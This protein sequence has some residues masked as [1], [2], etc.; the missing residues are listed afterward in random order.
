M[1]KISYRYLRRGITLM[2]VVLALLIALTVTTLAVFYY[3]SARQNL[4]ITDFTEEIRVIET[5]V[6]TLYGGSSY[7]LDRDLNMQDIIHSN[8]LPAKYVNG[9]TLSAMH[10]ITIELRNF[11]NSWYDTKPNT[12]RFHITGVSKNDCSALARFNWGDH[13]S[14][15]SLNGFGYIGGDL[16][17]TDLFPHLPYWCYDGGNN[18][19]I[20]IQQLF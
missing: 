16:S 11:A 19:D 15:F 12:I 4:D 1:K 18:I 10:G 3:N 8:M 17:K 5:T 6:D 7:S 13:V 9:N 2:E 20:G 14:Y